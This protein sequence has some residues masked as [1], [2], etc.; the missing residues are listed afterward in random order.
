MSSSKIKVQGQSED[1]VRDLR[2]HVLFLKKKTQK[3][4]DLTTLIV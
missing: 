2:I 1:H 3:K 4:H